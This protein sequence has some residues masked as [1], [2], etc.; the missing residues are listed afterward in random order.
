MLD[1]GGRLGFAEEA[2]ACA[3]VGSQGRLIT[4]RRRGVSVAVLGREYQAHAAGTQ[5]PQHP[6]RAEAADLV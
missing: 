1:G 3:G 6:I 5:D 2:L 4:L